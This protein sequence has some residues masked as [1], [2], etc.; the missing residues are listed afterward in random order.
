MVIKLT[1][2]GLTGLCSEEKSLLLDTVDSLRSHGISHYISLPQIIVCGDQSSGKS[3]VLEAISGVSFPVRSN[4]CTRFP[5]ELVLRKTDETA[6]HVSI[7]PHH[8]RSK[9]EK[10]TLR[11]FQEKL[12]TFDELPDLIERAKAAMGITTLGKAFSNDLLRIEVSGPDRPHLTIVDLPGLIHSETKTQSKDDV[13][14]IKQVVQG[15][16]KESRSVI[17]AVVSAKNDYAN[18]VVLKLAQKADPEGIRTLGVI[19]K[20]D[21]LH[22]GSESERDYIGLANNKD[23]EFRL[24]WHVLRNRDSEKD[25]WDPEER[26]SQE[27]DFFSKGSWASLNSS[28]WGIDLLRG[29]LS[30]LLLRQI[31]MELPNLIT[32][33]E[34]K[35]GLRQGQLDKLGQPRA[36]IDQQRTYLIRIGQSFQG[37]VKAAVEGN[38]TDSFFGDATSAAGYEKRIRAVIQ[39]RAIDFADNLGKK[40]K[41][42]HIYDKEEGDSSVGPSLPKDEYLDKIGALIQRSRGRELPGMFNPMIVADLFREQS[43]PWGAIARAYVKGVWE[44][45]RDFLRRVVKHVADSTTVSALLEFVIMPK[46]DQILKG[47]N[48]KAKVLLNQHQEGHPITYNHY[49][50]DTLQKIRMERQ[51]SEISRK[52]CTYF[53]VDSLSLRSGMNINLKAL[54]DHLAGSV[55]SDMNKFAALE[56]LDFLEAYY[57]VA[58][59]RFIDDVA[60]EVIEAGLAA[61][62]GKIIDPVSVSIMSTDELNKIAGET[63]ASRAFRKDLQTELTVLK[64]GMNIC[65]QF[66]RF[67]LVELDEKDGG[68]GKVPYNSDESDSIPSAAEEYESDLDERPHAEPFTDETP[69]EFDVPCSSVDDLI[70]KFSMDG[71]EL[72]DDEVPAP[73]YNRALSK[74]EKKKKREKERAAMLRPDGISY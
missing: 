11:G 41:Y 42:L 38:Y 16:M 60:V 26:N 64:D 43:S 72:A 10:A 39:N 35:S 34:T 59:K 3:S 68:G 46:L 8:S 25:S 6:V 54:V 66:A 36:T 58:M 22:P 33:I 24:G 57:K 4:V 18:Q 31:S 30:K 12:E 13:K 37:I 1:S 48:E 47:L 71:K 52:I 15:Y 45:A 27:K 65:K 40:G 74:K 69:P 56:V 29:R 7:V 70:K 67:G 53:Q 2:D 62:L 51:K 50:T 20:P 5:T 17:L 32:E 19:T 61:E 28:D 44:A 23:V 63:E 14:M 55:E 21:T 9:S 49:F 73:P